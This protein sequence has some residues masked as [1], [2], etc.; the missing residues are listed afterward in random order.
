MDHPDRHLHASRLH[1]AWQQAH[2]YARRMGRLVLPVS[3]QSVPTPRDAFVRARRRWIWR[4]RRTRSS[5]TRASKSAEPHRA[6]SKPRP[7]RETVMAGLHK[8][9]LPNPV[10][11]WINSRLPII[12]MMQKEYGVFPTPRNFNYFWNFG[13]LAM[14]TLVIMILTG[15]FLAM[16]Y[17][18]NTEPGIRQ[19][20]AHHARRELRLAD[21]LCASE[22][23]VD[24][25]HR[26][27]YPYFPRP[28][29]RILQG[30]ARIAVDAGRD[31]PAAD[32]GHRV[33][34]LR[35]AVGP[36][37]VLGRHRHHQPVLRLPG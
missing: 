13:A 26:H 1:P 4:C 19:R 20:A 32:D 30:A 27:L 5:P 8:S 17:Q 28:V 6:R 21:P 22:R 16:N 23:R 2:R 14:V 12:T 29:L 18:P 15:I 36:D 34:G 35:V 7:I 31:H 24:V 10:L 11:N 37:V 3:R 25:L 9:D 33:H